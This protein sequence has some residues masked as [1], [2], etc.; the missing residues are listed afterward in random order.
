MNIE[1]IVIEVVA[2]KF[3]RLDKKIT[4]NTHLYKDLNFDSLDAVEIIV[5][6]EEKFKVEL[7]DEDVEKFKTVK[8]LVK[9]VNSKL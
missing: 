4:L 8:D 6:L 1:N 9:I 2:N 7:Q 5:E 3:K